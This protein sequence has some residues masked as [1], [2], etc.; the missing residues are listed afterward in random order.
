MAVDSPCG[1]EAADNLIAGLAGARAVVTA[2]ERDELRSLLDA[3]GL[4]TDLV[5]GLSVHG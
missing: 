3:M 2:A 4:P 5:D 1:G